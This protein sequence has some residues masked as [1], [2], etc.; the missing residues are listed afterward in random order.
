M[1]EKHIDSN[2]NIRY[3]KEGTSILHREDG[4]ACEYTNGTKFWCLNNER[5]RTDG[6]AVEWAN[7]NNY[8]RISIPEMKKKSKE[9]LLEWL[10]CYGDNFKEYAR[11]AIK[12]LIREKE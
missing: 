5:H 4:P 10:L 6:P 8:W 7:G 3:Y 9:E 2:G 12:N 11:E 1:I